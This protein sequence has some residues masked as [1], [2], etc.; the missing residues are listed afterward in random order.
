[1]NFTDQLIRDFDHDADHRMAGICRILVIL[2]MLVMILNMCHVFKI[3]NAFY[4]A[5]L[6]AMGILTIPTILYDIM[7]IQRSRIARYFVLT[8]MVLMSGLL[9]AILSYHVIIMLIFP[10]VVACIYCDRGSVLYTSILNVPVMIVS[11]L[12]AFHLKIVPDEPLVTLRGVIVYGLIPRIIEMIAFSVICLSVT[13]KLQR[14][15]TNLVEK[16]NELYDNQQTL[17]SSLAELVEAQSHETGEHVK[18]V[19]AYT[20]ILCHALGFSDEETWKVSVASM[21]HD[22]GKIIVPREILHKP[23]HLEDDEFEEVK[24]HVDYGYNLLQNSP[25]EIMQIAAQIASQHHERYDGKGYGH[26]LKKDEISLYARCVAIAD[27]FDALVSKRCYK[28]AWTPEQAREEIVAQGGQQFDPKLTA[29]FDSHFEE[30][31]EVL[32]QYP[33]Q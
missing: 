25:G 11:H 21:M 14:L 31:L 13:G 17:I 12:I 19:A 2:M 24:K 10:I 1:M 28:E 29:L 30:F 33:D 3:T 22:V 6:I 5:V 7:H 18:R 26:H 16:N 23:G 27:V 15:I 9:Y 20:K 32:E 4:P 8:L